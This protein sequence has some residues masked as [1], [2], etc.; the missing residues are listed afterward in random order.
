MKTYTIAVLPGD[1][2]GPEVM[3]EALK[4]LQ[5]ISQAHPVSFKTEEG[6]IGGA[7]Y[8][9]FGT[10]LPVET[11]DL[12]RRSDAILLGSIGGPKWD[13][14]PTHLR[15]ELGGLLELRKS[16]CLFANLRPVILFDSVKELSPLAASRILKGVD[17]LTVREL[18]SD[19]YF[20]EPRHLDDNEG[21]DTMRYRSHEVQRIS[22]VAFE[23][24]QRRNKKVT[25]VD[26]SNV[27]CS[28]MLWRKVVTG[29]AKEYPG[30]A[31]NH[32]YV[33]N[34][35][36]QLILNPGQFDVILTSNLF[37]DILSDESA[38]LAGSLGMMPSASFGLDINLYEPAGGSAPDIAGKGTANPIAQVLS[39]AMMLEYSFNRPDLGKAIYNA[40]E[41]ALNEG[42]RTRDL[43]PA[44]QSYV[45]TFEMGDAIC[46]FL[47]HT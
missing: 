9:R 11:L 12:C 39:A 29:T 23:I 32:M 46:R 24:A 2:I 14:L 44:A 1:G 31:L 16:L 45:T 30:I 37:G 15:P 26:K 35:A 42:F 38:A 10:P 34:A 4:V 8:D 40:V 43:C 33:D 20:G 13:N 25:S 18:S 6:W 17:L 5:V 7:A 3:K 36:M 21:V 22:K 28:S 47:N 41:R 19:V 27:L